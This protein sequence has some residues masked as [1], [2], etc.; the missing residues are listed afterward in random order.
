M[1]DFGVSCGEYA[2]EGK[3]FAAFK[4]QAELNGVTYEFEPFDGDPPLMVVQLLMA[5]KSRTTEEEQRV[6]RGGLESVLFEM[7]DLS[8]GPGQPR[9][10]VA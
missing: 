2:M 4:R 3:A 10:S 6:G 8:L 9:R 5:C 1:R 7:V